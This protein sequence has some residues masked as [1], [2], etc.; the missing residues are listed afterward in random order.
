MGEGHLSI[1]GIR[2]V[3]PLRVSFLLVRKSLTGCLFWKIWKES[4]THTLI[5]YTKNILGIVNLQRIKIFK[6]F[7][8]DTWKLMGM[9][10]MGMNICFQKIGSRRDFARSCNGSRAIFLLTGLHKMKQ[11]Y[12]NCL[13]LKKLHLKF[14]YIHS[15][16]VSKCY[17]VI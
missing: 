12:Q 15:L 5:I 8:D 6:G 1:F 2:H 13:L 14:I 9:D 7:S 16:C 3:L 17:K 10:N 11:T 4:V